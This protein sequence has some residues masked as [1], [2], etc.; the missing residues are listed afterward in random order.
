MA[1]Q[2]VLVGAPVR[3]N[4]PLRLTES[5]VARGLGEL[6]V[7]ERQGNVRVPRVPARDSPA[8][9]VLVWGYWEA[10]GRT[11]PAAVYPITTVRCETDTIGRGVC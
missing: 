7:K 2:R 1:R 9:A 11:V 5:R 6:A 10:A 3:Q 4:R 8:V